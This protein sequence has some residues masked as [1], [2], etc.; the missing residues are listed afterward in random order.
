MI[1]LIQVDKSGNDLFEKDYSIVILVDKERVY[2]INI[3]KKLKDDLNS[4]FKSGELNII[5][6]SDKIR[7][8]RFRIRFHTALIIKLM[9]KAI[10]DLGQIDR[11]NIELCNDID[12]HF[13]EIKYMIFDHF[14]KL[15][16]SLKLEDIVLTKFEKPSLIDEAGKSFRT[17]DKEKL[18]NYTRINLNVEEL[19]R[20]IKK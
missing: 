19:I 9:E 5:K 8:N 18:K 11:M 16:P 1:T 4:R 2:G 20:I 10:F 14:F 13:H 7:K 17:N 12:G 3:P 6:G 15:I